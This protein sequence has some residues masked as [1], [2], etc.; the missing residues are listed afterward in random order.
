MSI[1]IVIEHGQACPKVICDQCQRPI[2]D[3]ALANVVWDEHRA[4]SYNPIFIHKECDQR[5][6]KAWQPLEHFLIYL[7]HNL[8]FTK[9]KRKDSEHM[10]NVMANL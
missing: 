7:E 1:Q 2:K 3:A 9:S 4:K 8:K 10:A 5:S 6:Y